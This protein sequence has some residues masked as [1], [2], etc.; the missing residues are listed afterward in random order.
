[1][2]FEIWDLG[3]G[4]LKQVN[5]DTGIPSARSGIGKI[6]NMIGKLTETE[7][8]EVLNEN[9][10]GRLGCYADNRVYVVPITFVFEKGN[11]LGRSVPGMK[12]DMMRKNPAV[13]FEVEEIRTY[14]N[15]RSVIAWGN[16]EE[17]TDEKEKQAALRAFVDRTLRMKISETAIA[18]ESTESR[19]HPRSPGNIKPVVFRIRLT[20]KTGRYERN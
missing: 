12:I 7:I 9:Y 15:W 1:M 2:G 16:Y 8:D 3:F 14:N 11:I 6:I 13:C 18:P 17:I 19:V 20:E 10:I 4:I 5:L